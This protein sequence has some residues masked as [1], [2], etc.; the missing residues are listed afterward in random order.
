MSNKTKRIFF[1]IWIALMVI[2]N[3]SIPLFSDFLEITSWIEAVACHVTYGLCITLPLMC[4]F[5]FFTS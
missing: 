3:I 2:G 4:I 5:A 1:I